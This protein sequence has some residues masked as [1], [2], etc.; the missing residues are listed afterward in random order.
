MKESAEEGAERSAAPRGALAA[1]EEERAPQVRALREL[2]A[3]VR[4]ESPLSAFAL[5]VRMLKAVAP[6]D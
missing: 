5:A 2:L 6:V 4:P 3:E 1:L